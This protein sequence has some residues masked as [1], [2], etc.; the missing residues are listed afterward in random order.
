[1]PVLTSEPLPSFPTSVVCLL[2]GKLLLSPAEKHGKG[3]TIDLLLF[4]ADY[5]NQLRVSSLCD[6]GKSVNPT[7][8]AFTGILVGNACWGW[9]GREKA[10]LQGHTWV[11]ESK[12]S[13]FGL[14]P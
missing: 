9:R 7:W 13:G 4:V 10:G 8:S 5:S 6:L 12:R 14:C 2:L 11:S 3:P 1:M